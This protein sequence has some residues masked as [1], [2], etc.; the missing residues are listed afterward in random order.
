[1]RCLPPSFQP[2][3]L[4]LSA[5][6][7]WLPCRSRCFLLLDETPCKIPLL[8]A[9]PLGFFLFNLLLRVSVQTNT[10][11]IHIKTS[12]NFRLYFGRKKETSVSLQLGFYRT[13]RAV[14]AH[15][16]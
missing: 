15:P 4:L 3:S 9:P 1:M 8:A 14:A 16:P 13:K 11:D 7:C 2:F 5:V 6:S 10:M 12:K